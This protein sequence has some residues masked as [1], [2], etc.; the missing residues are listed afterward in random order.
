MQ[1]QKD[2]K[3]YVL[4]RCSYFEIVLVV[5]PVGSRSQAH[6]H[7]ESNGLILILWGWIYQKMFQART[8]KYETTQY[9]GPGQWFREIPGPVHIMGNDSEDC[10]AISLHFYRGRLKMNRFS[11]EQLVYH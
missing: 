10:T 8:L 5:W 11:D 9:Y 6:D 2:Y 4:L 1:T 7:G 3:R